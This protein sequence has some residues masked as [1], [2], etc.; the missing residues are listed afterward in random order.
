MVL[1]SQVGTLALYFNVR[2]CYC[3]DWGIHL[4]EVIC[5]LPEWLFDR[6]LSSLDVRAGAGEVFAERGEFD[7]G[8]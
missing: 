6:Q 4:E 5:C 8:F 7:A 3:M 2:Q 1:A